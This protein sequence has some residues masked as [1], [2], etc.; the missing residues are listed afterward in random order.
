MGSIR[1]IVLSS[2]AFELFQGNISQIIYATVFWGIL[3]YVMW[4]IGMSVYIW[5]RETR[6]GIY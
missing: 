2:V 3:E 4:E 6:P 1:Y 5:W